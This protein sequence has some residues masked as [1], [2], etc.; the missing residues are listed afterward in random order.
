[1][2]VQ[3]RQQAHQLFT[4]L[5]AIMGAAFRKNLLPV[6]EMQSLHSIHRSGMTAL[7]DRPPAFSSASVARLVA[8]HYMDGWT[9]GKACFLSCW[10]PCIQAPAAAVLANCALL[11]LGCSRR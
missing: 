1:M 7:Q 9:P 11:C 5:T 8:E 6:R 4:S 2:M 3:D 10:V